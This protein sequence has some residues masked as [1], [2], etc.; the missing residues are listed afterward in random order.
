MKTSLTYHDS[1]SDSDIHKSSITVEV[2]EEVTSQPVHKEESRKFDAS[3]FLDDI[4]QMKLTLSTYLLLGRD[5][6]EIF[7]RSEVGLLTM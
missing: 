6:A 4:F 7:G 3:V 1:D 5:N 2:T